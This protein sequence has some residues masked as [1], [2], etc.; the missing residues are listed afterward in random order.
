[1]LHH[2]HRLAMRRA[3]ILVA[4]MTMGLAL[5]TAVPFWAGFQ[6]IDDYV[7]IHT[8]LE[9]ASVVIAVLVFASGWNAYSR[10]LPQH[11]LILACAFLGVAMLDFA[12]ALSYVGMPHFVTASSPQ[13]AINFWLVARLLAASALLTVAVLPPGKS[14]SGMSRHGW[15]AA[16]LVL[17][18][19]AYWVF[20]FHAD[21]VPQTYLPGTGLTPFKIWTEY[22]IIA[23][24]LA[25]AWSFCRAGALPH[26]ASRKARRPQWPSSPT[27]LSSSSTNRRPI[28]IPRPPGRSSATCSQLRPI[29]RSS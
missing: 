19:V 27:H 3:L 7:P 21:W 23:M 6:K 26:S 17:V 13:K 12:H 1:M 16:V 20:L 9:M 25:A 10:N 18:G 8:M 28:S 24:N 15:L 5:I 11:A 4:V 14:A 22:L 29:V 2:S